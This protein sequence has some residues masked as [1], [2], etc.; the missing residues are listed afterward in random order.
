LSPLTGGGSQPGKLAT[1]T[2]DLSLF[3]LEADIGE[4]TNVAEQQPDVVD[5]LMNF[6][7]VARDDLGDTAGLNVI[8]QKSSRIGCPLPAMLT[9]RPV[10]SS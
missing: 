4:T 6:V 10:E 3:D 9:G 1:Q 7:E 5:K 2:I 8:F